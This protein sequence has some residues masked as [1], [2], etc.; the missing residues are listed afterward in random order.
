V[1]EPL[2]TLKLA[3][4]G[5]E[6]REVIDVAVKPTG[7]PFSAVIVITETPDACLRKTALRASDG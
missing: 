1:L 2:A 4:A 3:S 7:L 5:F 6:P